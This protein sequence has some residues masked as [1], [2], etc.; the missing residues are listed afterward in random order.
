MT[1]TAF[2][3]TRRTRKAARPRKFRRALA[4]TTFVLLASAGAF[5]TLSS[6]LDSMT[7]RDCQAGV[8]RA[9]D[10]MQK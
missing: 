9:C 10:A 8:Q 4:T 5:W 7:W 1:T 6:T 2:P 3:R